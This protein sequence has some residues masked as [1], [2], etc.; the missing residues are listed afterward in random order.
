MKTAIVIPARLAS[1]RLPAKPLL[2]ET[3][4]YL[5]QHVYEQACQ[6][7][8]DTVLVAT[9]DPC[10]YRA[11]RGF[12]GQAT[13]TRSDHVSGTDRVAEAAAN[14]DADIIVNLQGDEPLIE[15]SALDL[16]SDLL[17][18]HADGDMA[19]LATPITC[20][21]Q[22]RDPNC[23]KVVRDGA[24]KAMYFSRS[25]IP[26]V[27][28]G[29]PDLSAGQQ[30]FLQHL[31]LYAYRREFLLRIAQL[32]RCPLEHVEKLEQ[33][34]MLGAGC[35]IQVGIVDHAAR[36]VDTPADYQQFVETYFR[37]RQSANVAA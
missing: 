7:R 37:Q 31:G 29:A 4:K 35:S 14:L 27:R 19:T 34:R 23:V 12:G 16:L 9:D 1:S 13:M 8:A 11:V 32:P 6:A 28:E 10:I 33:L 2:M 26:F 20:L 36:G 22:W 17:K 30:I 21:Q 24:G 3:G 25:P 18:S 15:P 5:V